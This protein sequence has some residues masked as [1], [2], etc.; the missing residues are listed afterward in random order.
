[1]TLNRS[2][3]L[4]AGVFALAATAASAGEPSFTGKWHW[5]Q[6]KSSLAE[7]E[8]QPQDVKATI[9]AAD[10]TRV[11]WVV[12]IVD[13]GG[14][15]H[16]ETFDGVPDGKPAPIKGSSDGTVAMFTLTGNIMKSTF[17]S[18]SGQTDTQSCALSEDQK[19]MNCSG[20]WN[21]GKGKVSKYV[22]VYD[23]M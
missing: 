15:K 10:S 13:H 14:N 8:V 1:M 11:S 2:L 17:K 23:R 7:G 20:V 5:N 18:Q 22:D 4:A 21:D 9:E 3:L 19:S 6:S 12:T 16:V